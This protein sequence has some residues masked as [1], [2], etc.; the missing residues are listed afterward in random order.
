M[1]GPSTWRWWHLLEFYEVKRGARHLTHRLTLDDH[2]FYVGRTRDYDPAAD[3]TAAVARE[4]LNQIHSPAGRWLVAAWRLDD[5]GRK[6]AHRL[7]EV[8][9]HWCGVAPETASRALPQK[10]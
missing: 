8:Q 9:F 5:T 4:Y 2:G 6:K 3:Y 1:T 7:C 10:S